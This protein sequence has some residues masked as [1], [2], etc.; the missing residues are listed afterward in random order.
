MS[1]GGSTNVDLSY[2]LMNRVTGIVDS[3]G[4]NSFLYDAEGQVTNKS[5]SFSVPGFSNV[6]YEI[7]YAFDAVGNVTNRTL[8]GTIGFTEQ[9]PTF[10]TYDDVNRLT[11]V[12]NAHAHAAY[13]YDVTNRYMT[14]TYGNGDVTRNEYDVEWRPTSIATSNGSTQVQGWSYGYNAMGMITGIFASAETNLYGY[15]AIYQLTSETVMDASSSNATT[16]RYDEAGNR[17]AEIGPTQTNRYA[18][19]ADNE[20][21][22]VSDDAAIAVTGEVEPGPNSN[23]WYYT[24]ASTDGISARVS[25]S[26]GTFSIPGVPVTQGSNTFT[27]TVEDVSGNAATQTVSFTK[28][29]VEP[30]A[31]YES[32]GNGNLTKEIDFTGGTPVTNAY[33]YDM[34]NRLTK[35]TSNGVA[36]LECWYDGIG[37]RIAKREILGGVTNAVQYVWEG[38]SIMAV[39]DETGALLES[40]TRGVGVAYDIGSLVAVHHHSGTH[41]GLSYYLHHNHRGDVTSVQSGTSTI[42]TYSYAAYGEVTPETG[43][44]ESRFGFSSKEED[45]AAGLLYFGFR[46]YAPEDG[47][48]T[49]QDPIGLKGGMNQY[50]AFGGNAVCFLDMLGLWTCAFGVQ[51][52]LAVLFAGGLDLGFAFGHSDTAGWT[53]APILFSANPGLGLIG[54]SGGGFFQWTSADSVHDLLGPSIQFGPSITLPPPLGVDFGV[55]GIVAPDL[56]SEKPFED[57]LYEGVQFNVGVGGPLP[58]DGHVYVPITIGWILDLTRAHGGGGGW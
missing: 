23:K 26:D 49:T 8:R 33:F 27:V 25:P 31:T 1:Y 24:W 20:L 14:K 56:S 17:L 34:E 42:A 41:S 44:Y 46:Y 52:E 16:W 57:A 7:D 22:W 45:A 58:V 9:I 47:R 5:V 38:W 35:A 10:F 37:R 19:N 4:T 40:Y 43:T 18:Y 11:L 30:S 13:A 12:S 50:V 28:Q 2:D 55:D 36:V 3:L 15:D 6:A 39:L 53:F 21:T 32:D 51:G 48:W 29:V 54:A